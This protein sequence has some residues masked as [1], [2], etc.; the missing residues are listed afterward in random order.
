MAIAE[1]VTIG[2]AVQRG[3]VTEEVVEAIRRRPKANSAS[4]PSAGQHCYHGTLEH[5]SARRKASFH[6]RGWEICPR[7]RGF[8][9]GKGC[10]RCSLC[11]H[12]GGLLEGTAEWQCNA[13]FSKWARVCLGRRGEGVHVSGDFFPLFT[14]RFFPSPPFAC[15]VPASAVAVVDAS[16]GFFLFAAFSGSWRLAC[17]SQ[18]GNRRSAH[19]VSRNCVRLAAGRSYGRPAVSVSVSVG[20]RG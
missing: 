1:D 19:L 12:R 8:D 6:S 14:S 10:P 13:A 2:P 17:K 20:C 15:L 18:K 9:G 16:V 11:L 3:V 7:V 4:L 5:G